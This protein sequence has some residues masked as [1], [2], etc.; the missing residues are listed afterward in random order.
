MSELNRQDWHDEDHKLDEEFAEVI[1]FVR[2]LPEPQ[3]PPRLNSAVMQL[4]RTQV[5]DN[6][7]SNWLLGQGPRVILVTLILFAMAM[8]VILGF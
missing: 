7:D 4:A 1:P 5:D 2:D 6:L 8:L 3:V